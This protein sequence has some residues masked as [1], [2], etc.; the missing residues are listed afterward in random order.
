MKDQALAITARA[1]DPQNAKNEL[2]EYLQHLILRKM[3]ELNLNRDFVFHGGTAL[4]ILYDLA[5]FSEDLDFHIRS[6]ANPFDFENMMVRIKKDLDLNGYT[7]STKVKT[8]TAVNSAFIQFSGLLFEAGLSP[9]QDENLSIKI[10]IDT[11]PPSGFDIDRSMVNRYFPYSVIH[12]DRASFLAGKCHAILRRPYTKG[13]DYFDLMFYLSRWKNILPNFS[14]L[15]NCLTQSGY[16]GESFSSGNWKKLL[17]N[18][19]ESIDWKLVKEDVSPFI[20]SDSDLQL[21]A[22]D[23]FKQLLENE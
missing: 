22:L 9:L 20:G 2:R 12:H 4:R 15:N 8:G 5:R 3:F 7:L 17:L 1:T 21:L 16:D 13:R 23:Y 6:E 19:L 18:R 10:E 14:Y 11:R